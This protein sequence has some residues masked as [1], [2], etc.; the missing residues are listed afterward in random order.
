MLVYLLRHF[1]DESDRRPK[2]HTMIQAVILHKKKI[3]DSNLR[4]FLLNTSNGN[5]SYSC[6]AVLACFLKKTPF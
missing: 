4:I 1:D 2:Y 5:I 3:S 6:K